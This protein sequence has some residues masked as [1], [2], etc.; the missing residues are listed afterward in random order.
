MTDALTLRIRW[1]LEAPIAPTL[2][3]LAA[4]FDAVGLLRR[5]RQA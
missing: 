4:Q 5:V 1:L 3:P 2:L